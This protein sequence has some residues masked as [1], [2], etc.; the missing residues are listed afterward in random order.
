M[1]DVPGWDLEKKLRMC[2]DS[3]FHGFWG[4]ESGARPAE[5]AS[6]AEIFEA[7]LAAVLRIK[8][9]LERVVLGRG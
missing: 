1:K 8:A 5:G 2:M 9:V 6:P 4:I 3:G 7:E